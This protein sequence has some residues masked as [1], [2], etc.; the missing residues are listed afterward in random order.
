MKYPIYNVY[1]ELLI[2]DNDTLTAGK[3]IIFYEPFDWNKI[4][5]VFDEKSLIL[6]TQTPDKAFNRFQSHYKL[7]EAAG[8]LILNNES[9]WLMIYRLGKWDLPKGK[10]DEGENSLQAAV[11][12]MMEECNVHLNP[13]D[14]NFFEHTYHTYILNNKRILKKTYWYK[15]YY[16]KAEKLT[17]QTEEN[18]EK[19]EWVSLRKW[20]KYQNNSY[21]S[22]IQVINK[23]LN[24]DY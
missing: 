6:I 13:T 24:N 1:N 22:I 12:E 2:T 8:G 14:C 20:E 17:P 9:Q 5:S 7:I 3:D 21:P 23:Y 16:N 15:C 10:I 11:R 18:I 4:I 19:V